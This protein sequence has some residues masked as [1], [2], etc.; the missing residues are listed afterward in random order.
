MSFLRDVPTSTPS[1]VF[2]S[3]LTGFNVARNGGSGAVC[4][5]LVSASTT[6]YLST[7]IDPQ[8]ASVTLLGLPA[9]GFMA[10]NIINTQAQPGMLANY[11][12]AFAH[13]VGAAQCASGDALCTPP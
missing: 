13:R 8:G 5:D 6:H 9:T 2:G 1:G 12:G 11:G 3:T 4:L 7:G 10:Y